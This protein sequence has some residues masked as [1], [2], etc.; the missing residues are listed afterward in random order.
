MRRTFS[1]VGIYLGDGKFIHSPRTG[2]SIRIED[3]NV[4]YWSRHF[5][6]GRRAPE[7]VAPAASTAT[8]PSR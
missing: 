7:L 3:I 5:T 4:T 6:G 1:H 8:A 2:Q